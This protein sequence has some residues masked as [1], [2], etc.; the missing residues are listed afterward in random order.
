MH[1]RSHVPPPPSSPS[2][3]AE[4]R[5]CPQGAARVAG[6][7]A[8]ASPKGKPFLDAHRHFAFYRHE[9]LGQEVLHFSEDYVP[10]QFKNVEDHLSVSVTN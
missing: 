5:S 4:M 3:A 7:H 6:G 9:N 1:S 2:P 10:Q 8:P